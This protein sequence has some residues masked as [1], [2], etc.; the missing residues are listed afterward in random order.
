F[1]RQRD[2]HDTLG[3]GPDSEEVRARAAMKSSR[4]LAG[5]VTLATAL[6]CAPPLG[7]AQWATNPSWTLF[8]PANDAQFTIASART[9]SPAT[10]SVTVRF[11]VTNLGYKPMYVPRGMWETRRCGVA[12]HLWMWLEYSDGRF[13][14]GGYGGSCAGPR[15]SPDTLQQSVAKDA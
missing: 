14:G 5:A 6:L 2:T 10:G 1:H 3:R 12:P 9:V 13:S 15:T 4:L 11:D 7:A 8:A